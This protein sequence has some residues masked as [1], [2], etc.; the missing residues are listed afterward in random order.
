VYF[1]EQAGFRVTAAYDRYRLRPGMR[2]AGPAVVEERE[3]TVVVGPGAEVAVD[4]YRN[5]LIVRDR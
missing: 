4:D 1:P 2:F 5:L 3:S